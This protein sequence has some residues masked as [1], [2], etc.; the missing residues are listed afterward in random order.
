MINRDSG[1]YQKHPAVAELEIVGSSEIVVRFKEEESNNVSIPNMGRLPLYDPCLGK[2]LVQPKKAL[3]TL[4]ER[5]LQWN[6]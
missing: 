6:N 1:F 2:D 5:F 4:R 3:E